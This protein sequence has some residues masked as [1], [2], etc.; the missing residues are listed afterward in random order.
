MLHP[1][2][3]LKKIYVEHYIERLKF[4]QSQTQPVERK[5]TKKIPINIELALARRSSAVRDVNIPIITTQV[6]REDMDL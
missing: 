6:I 2:Y 5:M 3:S 1:I 4:Y